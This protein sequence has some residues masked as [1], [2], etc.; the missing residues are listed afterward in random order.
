MCQGKGIYKMTQEQKDKR[1]KIFSSI[2]ISI[3]KLMDDVRCECL[4]PEYQKRELLKRDLDVYNKIVKNI[5]IPEMYRQFC[6]EKYKLPLKQSVIDLVENRYFMSNDFGIRK[7]GFLFWSTMPG[8]GKTLLGLSILNA[9]AVQYKMTV[10]YIN[11]TVFFHE[12]K[13]IYN[14]DKRTL[15]YNETDLLDELVRVDALMFD[16]IGTE[17]VS[18][19]IREKLYYIQEGRNVLSNKINI[20]T[21]NDS[22]DQLSNKIGA[23]IISRIIENSDVIEFSGEDW[24]MKN[25]GE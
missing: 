18:D 13:K 6:F 9:L 17:K 15:L 19:W 21:S 3:E 4:N 8:T 1:N 22:P 14:M 16:D 25:K 24:R 20:Y 12:L 7:T 2:G 10:K 11:T 23:K 5:N